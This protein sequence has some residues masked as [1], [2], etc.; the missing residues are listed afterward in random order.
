MH[1]IRFSG[2]PCLDR[3]LAVIGSSLALRI[4]PRQAAL[5]SVGSVV[6]EAAGQLD[7]G[8]GPEIIRKLKNWARKLIEEKLW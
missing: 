8:S 6:W 1:Q 5:T 3:A 2:P 4:S 7:S